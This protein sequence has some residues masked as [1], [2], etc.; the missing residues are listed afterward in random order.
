MCL[1]VITGCLWLLLPLPLLCARCVCEFSFVNTWHTQ[2]QRDTD[3]TWGWY[4]LFTF[5]WFLCESCKNWW[6]AS[7]LSGQEGDGGALE[8]EFR[9]SQPIPWWAA[10]GSLTHHAASS[11]WRRAFRIKSHKPMFPM[12]PSCRGTL[13]KSARQGGVTAGEE[14]GP[15]PCPRRGKPSRTRQACLVWRLL[16]WDLRGTPQPLVHMNFKKL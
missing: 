1:S 9:G 5:V 16:T 6:A 4:T 11:T 8:D 15:G 2:L 7:G 10:L 13:R 3:Y 12:K 14:E